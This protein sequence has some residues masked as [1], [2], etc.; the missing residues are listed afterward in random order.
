MNVGGEGCWKYWANISSVNSRHLET[1]WVSEVSGTSQ[2]R[3]ERERERSRVRRSAKSQGP[4]RG[5]MSA[6][7]KGE[8]RSPQE[9]PRGLRCSPFSLPRISHD[10]F[11]TLAAHNKCTHAQP[12]PRTRAPYRGALLPP[13]V[14]YFRWRRDQEPGAGRGATHSRREGPGPAAAGL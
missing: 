3:L 6:I 2:R 12:R 7:E 11:G 9:T 4:E 8:Q 14:K 10:Y 1:R 13:E 5:D